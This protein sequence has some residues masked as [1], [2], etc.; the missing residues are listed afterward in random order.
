M[1]QTPSTVVVAGPSAVLAAPRGDSRMLGQIRAGTVVQVLDQWED[2]YLVSAPAASATPLTWERGWVH[3]KALQLPGGRRAPNST[4]G[5]FM[6]R[7]FG[8]AG[9]LLF[10]A[11]NSF[12]TILGNKV[13]SEF[14]GGGQ[15]VLRNGI[16]AQASIARIRGTGTRALVSGNRV[17]T[18]GIANRLTLTP[19]QVTAGYRNDKSGRLAPY[20]GGG[21]GWHSLE[22][23]YVGMSAAERVRTR[24]IGYHVVGGADYP[25]LRWMSMGG[26]VQWATVPKALGETGVSAVYDE[27]DLGGTTFRL[28]LMV[29]Y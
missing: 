28:K 16:F 5:R 6:L 27:H 2:W 24:H 4:G 11:T 20:F 18:M 22:E 15:I 23:D 10:A 3:A 25:L 12:E 9:G 13:N 17:F 8:H 29:G 1:A 7:G 21:V 26:E 19:I 14:G